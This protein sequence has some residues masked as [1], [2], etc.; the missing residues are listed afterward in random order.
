MKT[1]LS[2]VLFLLSCCSLQAQWH[3]VNSNTTED[4]AQLVFA[5]V[6]T[7]YFVSNHSIFKTTDEGENW[8]S[9]FEQ[10]DMD[11]H[12]IGIT[13]NEIYAFAKQSGVDKLILSSDNGN[14]WSLSTINYYPK[15]VMSKTGKIFFLDW[16]D[17]LRLKKID[18]S[19]TNILSNYS[20]VLFGIHQNEIIMVNDTYD[21]FY[22]STDDGQNWSALLGFPDNFSDNNANWSQIKSFGNTIVLTASY[23][24]SVHLSADNGNTWDIIYDENIPAANIILDSGHIYGMAQCNENG[25]FSACLTGSID[26]GQTW[27]VIQTGL[28]GSFIDYNL[29]FYDENIGFAYTD[30]GIIYKTSNGG[31]L[32]VGQPKN[33]E[34]KIKVYPNPGKEKVYIET[35]GLSLEQPRL[36]TLEGRQIDINYTQENNQYILDVTH[37]AFG[38]YM[39]QL[40]NQAGEK[41]TK[42]LVV[43]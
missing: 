30:D 9:V 16:N 20:S 29:Y 1:F 34:K 17:N 15:N 31:G 35:N 8:T 28:L 4:I 18:G 36:Y 23:G 3:Q 12:A 37:L 38:M 26:Y 40:Q 41:V 7:G 39:L 43:E 19:Q 33:I 21:T 27:E 14:T 2:I 10:S 25:E 24:A 32:N 22:K 11:I 5:D 13:N 6:N 42:K